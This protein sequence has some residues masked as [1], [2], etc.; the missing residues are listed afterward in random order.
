MNATVEFVDE[1]PEPLRTGGAEPHFV[2][3]LT[4]LVAHP[5]QWGRILTKEAGNGNLSSYPAAWRRSADNGGAY[6]IFDLTK[7]E[8]VTRTNPDLTRSLYGRYVN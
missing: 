1:V 7:F 4:E 6:S 3:A 2:D 5:G 8:F